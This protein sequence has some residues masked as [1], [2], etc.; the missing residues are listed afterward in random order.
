MEESSRS[1]MQVTF[2]VGFLLQTMWWGGETWKWEGAGQS[3]MCGVSCKGYK[4]QR[5]KGEKRVWETERQ[6]GMTQGG[7]TG[8]GNERRGESGIKGKWAPQGW[9]ISAWRRGKELGHCTS[10]MSFPGCLILQLLCFSCTGYCLTG[11]KKLYFAF[12]Q[13]SVSQT[14]MEWLIT[15]S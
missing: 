8:G 9:Q 15:E 3:Q 5:W 11:E 2:Q 12:I 6:D 10:V 13:H 4:L 1:S 14:S 7:G